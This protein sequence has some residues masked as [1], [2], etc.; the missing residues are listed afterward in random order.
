M[1]PLPTG[2]AIA[3]AIGKRQA[4]IVAALQ[5]LDDSGMLSE[6]RLAGWDRLTIGCHLRYGAVA[7]ERLTSDTLVGKASAYYPEGRERQ[8][9]TTLRPE[10]G[11]STA[12]VVASLHE[13]GQRLDAVL[14]EVGDHRWTETI[15]EPAD[16]VDLGPIE[17]WTL[18]LLRLTELEVHGQDLDLGLSPW[19]NTFVT[20]ALPTRLR[21]LP[22]RRSNHRA[23]DRAVAGTWTL[24]SLDGASFRVSAGAHHVEVSETTGDSLGDVTMTGTSEQ[25]LAFVLGR[26]PLSSLEVDGDQ[27]LGALFLSAFPGP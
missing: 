11:E 16:K 27:D 8:R 20:A 25:L 2:V 7:T 17:L 12:D 24:C 10:S 23:V 1:A 22:R 18:A 5:L 14:A 13:A 21:W 19:S 6:T 15:S 26:A 3:A 9:P 4:E